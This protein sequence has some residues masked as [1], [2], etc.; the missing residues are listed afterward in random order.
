[1]AVDKLVDGV[2]NRIS[3]KVPLF[4]TREAQKEKASL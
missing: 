3:D 4:S 2:E 1:M